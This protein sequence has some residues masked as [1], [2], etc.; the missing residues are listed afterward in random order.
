MRKKKKIHYF[1]FFYFIEFQTALGVGF[2]SRTPN[3]LTDVFQK[4]DEEKL[5]G[6]TH[7]EI[8]AYIDEKYGECAAQCFQAAGAFLVTSLVVFGK[9]CWGSMRRPFAD[10]SNYHHLS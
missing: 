5:H 10:T 7:K 4:I 1:I 2:H 9:T 6:K 8:S 3:L